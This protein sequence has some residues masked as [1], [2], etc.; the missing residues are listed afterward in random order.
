[1]VSTT[2]AKSGMLHAAPQPGRGVTGLCCQ[3]AL[4]F[5]AL[6]CHELLSRL[7]RTVQPCARL[8]ATSQVQS[9]NVQWVGSQSAAL[10]MRTALCFALMKCE[11]PIGRQKMAMQGSAVPS[12]QPPGKCQSHN[13]KSAARALALSPTVAA[14][15]LRRS[16]SAGLA[17]P[18][19][20][21][22]RSCSPAP[23]ASTAYCPTMGPWCT[24]QAQVPQSGSCTWCHQP[25]A[26]SEPTA[27]LLSVVN[28]LGRSTSSSL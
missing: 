8:Q 21:P 13:F 16:D 17:S 3:R 18:S 4:Q 28:Q 14:A 9:N 12:A 22:L 1:M 2:L 27:R 19:R 11:L 15:S 5:S 24:C 6:R 10:D 23:S 20:S 7:K 26:F 25:T